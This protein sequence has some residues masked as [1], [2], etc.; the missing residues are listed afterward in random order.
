LAGAALEAQKD[1][2]SKPPAG[3][4]PYQERAVAALL[5]IPEPTVSA[6]QAGI[7]DYFDP[8][9]LLADIYYRT[10]QYD[11]MNALAEGL[12]K[13]LDESTKAEYGTTVLALTLYAKLGTAERDYG[14]GKYAQVCAGLDPVVK[15]MMDPAQETTFS[16][17][18]E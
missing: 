11:K 12:L 18:R 14:A 17:L 7:H 9:H 5:K 3:K 2:E 8:R 15:Q 10:K 6:D 1:P 4:P 16:S 13:R